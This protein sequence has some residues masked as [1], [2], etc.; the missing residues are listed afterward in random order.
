[1]PCNYAGLQ[2]VRGHLMAGDANYSIY[3][4]GLDWQL[5]IGCEREIYLTIGVQ[6]RVLSQVCRAFFALDTA[7]ISSQGISLSMPD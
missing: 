6:R 1:M 5:L 3:S 7:F 2:D 4:Y